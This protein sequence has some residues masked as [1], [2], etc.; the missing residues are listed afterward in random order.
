M[1]PTASIRVVLLIPLA[2]SISISV[3]SGTSGSNPLSSSGESAN[4]RFRYSGR[5]RRHPAA[6]VSQ[7]WHT[8]KPAATADHASTCTTQFYRGW[9]D[10]VNLDGVER[11]VI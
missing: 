7:G 11:I 2:N 6:I 8:G 3:A 4:D 5:H 10:N 9:R 1:S